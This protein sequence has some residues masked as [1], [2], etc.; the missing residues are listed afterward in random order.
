VSIVSAAEAAIRR[1]AEALGARVLRC[2]QIS[3]GRT[4]VYRVHLSNDTPKRD[5]D[6]RLPA[7][8]GI[9]AA[10]ITPTDPS[11]SGPVT[12]QRDGHRVVRA[13]AASGMRVA[14]P[15]HPYP[16]PTP[17]GTVAFW[18]WL[19]PASALSAAGWGRLT[20]HLH[21][22]G[23]DTA[24]ALTD[25]SIGIYDPL[26]AFGARLHLAHAHMARRRHPLHGRRTLLRNL[27]AALEAAV[28]RARAAATGSTGILVHGDN[29][30]GN[31]LRTSA[32]T[33][34]LADFE[35]L[36]W[37]PTALDWSALLLG[38]WHYG[39]SADHAREFHHGYG[40]LAPV[41]DLEAALAQAEPFARVRELSGV[42]VAMIAAGDSSLWEREMRARLPTI[43]DPGL[44]DRWTFIGRP[45]DMNLTDRY[46]F[47][48]TPERKEDPT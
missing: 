21:T 24:R 9:V 15:L 39:F 44:G 38:R 11:A 23:T 6:N 27:E 28:G 47:E 12:N 10:R 13:L 37:G 45:A 2:E 5:G 17:K 19:T 1:A 26:S 29:Q 30:P 8:L 41:V 33:P 4:G 16:V 14:A 22:R 3:V 48:G 7:G 18:E 36:A 20:A 31:V 25:V 43:A 42:L 46:P 40:T 34:V 32:G 35:R